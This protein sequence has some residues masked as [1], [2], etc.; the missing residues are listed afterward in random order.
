MD[1]NSCI[2]KFFLGTRRKPILSGA[3]KKTRYMILSEM[4]QCGVKQS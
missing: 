3:M 4:Q 2:R 1:R